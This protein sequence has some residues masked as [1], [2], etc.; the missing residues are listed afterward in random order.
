MLSTE[1]K[2]RIGS[3]FQSVTLTA[4]SGGCVYMAGGTGRGPAAGICTA[5]KLA[6]GQVWAAE[7]DLFGG[8]GSDFQLSDCLSFKGIGRPLVRLRV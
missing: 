2:K 3:E 7:G 1:K 8:S 5:S 6:S 4:L